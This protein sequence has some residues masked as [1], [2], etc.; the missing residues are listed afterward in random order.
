MQLSKE[1]LFRLAEVG[2]RVTRYADME[3]VDPSMEQ[4][5]SLLAGVLDRRVETHHIEAF[6]LLGM[7]LVEEF[8]TPVIAEVLSEMF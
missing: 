5:A 1:I 3:V 7:E 6:Y 4:R 8:G 2:S